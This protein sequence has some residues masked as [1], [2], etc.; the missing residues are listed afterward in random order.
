[1][2]LLGKQELV[3]AWWTTPNKAFEMQCPKDADL[4]KVV[5]YIE[6]FCF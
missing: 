3:K 5:A 2:S 6:R 1:M 4:D